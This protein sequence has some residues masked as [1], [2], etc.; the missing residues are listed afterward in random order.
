MATKAST[1]NHVAVAVQALET[2]AQVATDLFEARKIGM[3][4]TIPDTVEAAFVL[5]HGEEGRK[6]IDMLRGNVTITEIPLVDFI[7]TWG[8]QVQPNGDLFSH[9]QV[10]ELDPHK[11]WTITDDDPVYAGFIAL[12]GF[13]I[14]AYSGFC[15]T[16]VPW[17]EEFYRAGGYAVWWQEE[18]DCAPWAGK[19]KAK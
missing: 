7:N 18:D 16:T 9:Q 4:V 14:G 15:V 12:P 6:V 1:E 11:V 2:L 17:T 13:Y 8:A 10:A 19:V 3:E 5:K